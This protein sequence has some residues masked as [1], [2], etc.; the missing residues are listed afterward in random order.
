[1]DG[2]SIAVMFKDGA[3]AAT[4]ADI[5]AFKD[6]TAACPPT[7]RQNDYKSK[8]TSDGGTEGK[9]ME[10]RLLCNPQRSHLQVYLLTI[11]FHLK[12]SGDEQTKVLENGSYIIYGRPLLL[13]SMPKIGRP[14]HMDN[15]T[16]HKER[17]TYARCLVEVDMSQDLV[18]SVLLTLPDGEDYEQIV[19][20]ERTLLDFAPIAA[21]WVTQ[22]RVLR[23]TNL[24]KLDMNNPLWMLMGNGRNR[25]QKG[26]NPTVE[27]PWIL[28][29]D[30]NNVL[31][32]DEKANGLPV[33]EYETRDFRNC[34][35]DL[36][37]SDLRF[38]GVFY[39]WSNN[40]VWCKLDRAMVNNKWSQEGILAQTVYEFPGKFS[41]HSSCTITLM[42]E[43]DRGA[44]P[45][46]FFNMW[47]KHD[48]FLE[49]VSSSW[50]ISMV[51]T[52]M[53]KLC[54]KLKAVKEPLKTLNRMHFAH[55]SARAEAAE[56]ELI[57]A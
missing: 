26:F 16:V 43:N 36:G 28:L 21:L 18:Q 10:E 41:D 56:E 30:F 6:L 57:Q 47:S 50:R 20:Y 39:T 32:N 17:I 46:K 38:S 54:K 23:Q 8:T 42:E 49:V 9:A 45:F 3:T 40:S 34:C 22:M 35:Y 25:T 33:T 12:E 48:S 19:F 24:V 55:I 11:G 5:V 51:G 31:S 53:Y 7:V 1:M 13:K 27:R 2:R 15:L 14:L 44:T 52:K 29:G 4:K 37:I